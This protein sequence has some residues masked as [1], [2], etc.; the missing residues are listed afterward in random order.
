MS[1]L[2]RS[3]VGVGMPVIL[4]FPEPVTR[5]AE[6][7]RRLEISSSRPVTGSWSWVSD[8]E[9]HYRPETYWPAHT[10][11]TVRAPLR[12]VEAADGLWGS[13]TASCGSPPAPRSSAT[14]TPGPCA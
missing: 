8:T 4:R 6:V 12:G 7:E 10:E 14:S 5:K 1:P 13:R 11:V 3:T 9:V 2:D